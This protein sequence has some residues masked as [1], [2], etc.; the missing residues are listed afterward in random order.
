VPA[1]MVDMVA[2]WS[3][4]RLGR[5][6]IDL[7][8]FPANSTPRVSIFSCTSMAWIRRPVRTGDVSDAR[9][10]H[11]VRTL[12]D[13]RAGHDRPEPAKVDGIQL[14]RRRLEDNDADK[15]AAIVAAR[16]RPASAALPGISG[17]VWERSC[18]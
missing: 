13:P 7:L 12:D 11:R 18:A 14:G 16:A 4:D 5:S 6:L 3:V 17:W 9:R 1:A 15:V 8:D 10:V 2:A